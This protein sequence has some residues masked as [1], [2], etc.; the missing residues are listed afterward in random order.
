MQAPE[1]FRDG[2]RL[3][4]AGRRRPD[5]KTAPCASKAAGLS[6]IC[7]ISE[8]AAEAKGYADAMMLDDRGQ[9]TEAAEFPGFR[10]DYIKEAYPA[11]T[12]AAE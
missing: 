11:A 7:T 10:N 5:S 8:H 6:M 3:D 12:I 1:E 2:F 9:V 4:I